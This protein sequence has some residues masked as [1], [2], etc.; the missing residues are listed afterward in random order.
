M[1]YKAIGWCSFSEFLYN[2]YHDIIVIKILFLVLRHGNF[3][4]G[5]ICI[6]QIVLNAL[7]VERV[8]LYTAVRLVLL[9][10]ENQTVR[11][12]GVD[13]TIRCN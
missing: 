3:N 6:F 7:L 9:E 5:S 13:I 8:I 4:L 10:K 11:K 12:V 2:K 1:G